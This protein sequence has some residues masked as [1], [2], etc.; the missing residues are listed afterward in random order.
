MG[1]LILRTILLTLLDNHLGSQNP[2]ELSLFFNAFAP[3]DPRSYK[4][5][6]GRHIDGEKAAFYL[7]TQTL[8]EEF[9]GR[10]TDSGQPVTDQIIPFGKIRGAWVQDSDM[11]WHR[12]II[13]S[14]PEQL[15]RTGPPTLAIR[16]A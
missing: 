13:P 14:G 2:E 11:K 1:R 12:L 10:I 5:A 7:P 15:I 4:L 6:K 9:E 16:R 3:W 8:M